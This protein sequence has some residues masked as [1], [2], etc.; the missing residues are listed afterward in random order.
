MSFGKKKVNLVK[1]IIILLS[2]VYIKVDDP[3]EEV[4]YKFTYPLVCYHK[5][6]CENTVYL[7]F[8]DRP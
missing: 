6:I 1:S 2:L 5:Y 3:Q 4:T 7:F 8:L